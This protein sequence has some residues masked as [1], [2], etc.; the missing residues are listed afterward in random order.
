MTSNDLTV[1]S[2]MVKGV[3][4][5][6][7]EMPA[8]RAAHLMAKS[9]IRHLVVTEN[10]GEVLGVL[11]Q[12]DVLKHL[13]PWLTSV[14][15]EDTVDEGQLPRCS[16]RE[17]MSTR[18]IAVTADTPICAAAGI[19][20]SNRI[21]CLPVVTA[22]KRLVGIVTATDLLQFMAG[23]PSPKPTGQPQADAA[24]V[25][26]SDEGGTAPARPAA[27]ERR[28]SPR[29][30]YPFLQ[31]LAPVEA[32][33]EPLLE[34]FSETRCLDI[35]GGGVSFQ[36]DARPEFEKCVVGLGN[37]PALVYYHARVV[38]VRKVDRKNGA[39]YEVGCEF[40]GRYEP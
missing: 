27:D 21:G 19:L 23:G 14:Q 9:Q 37:P 28:A 18:L 29:H 33:E 24:A 20:A 31:K 15:A 11:S 10:Y 32:D 8:I 4:A 38:R 6:R 12:S 26:S 36:L 7:P 2:I 25:P 34:S 35:S 30:S 3:R 39:T 1:G 16:V 40:V 13:S 5:V 17:I 22:R